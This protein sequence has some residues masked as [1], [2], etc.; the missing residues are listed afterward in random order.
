MTTLHAQITF[1]IAARN[2]ES[3]L[4]DTLRS[5]ICQSR[6]DWR[7]VVVDDHSADQ[8]PRIANSTGDPRIAVIESPGRGVAAARNA[9]FALATT[10]LVAFPDAD[11]VLDPHF[12]A[13][14]QAALGGHDAVACG[15]R[16]LGPGLVRGGWEAIPPPGSSQ[17]ESLAQENPFALGAVVSRIDALRRL[18]HPAGGSSPVPRLFDERTHLEDWDLLLRLS[19]SGASWAPIVPEPL[20]GYRLLPNSRT[21]NLRPWW[22]DGLRLIRR[23]HPLPRGAD[24]AARHWTLRALAR[25]AVLGHHALAAELLGWLGGLDQSDQGMLTSAVRAAVRRARLSGDPAARVDRATWRLAV[26]RAMGATPL[27]HA[28]V[29]RAFEGA[30]W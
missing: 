18:A 15:C 4:P 29:S 22:E 27:A 8:T 30:R 11:D 21:A 12:H 2:A 7:A 14:L 13:C 5:L 1:V 19:G 23:Y 3:T 25:A 6:P 28:A 26:A 24:D 16:F 10:P 20:Y 9:G 17:L